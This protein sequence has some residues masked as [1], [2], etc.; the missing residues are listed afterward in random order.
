[1]AG[2][3]KCAVGVPSVGPFGDP[4]LLVELGRGC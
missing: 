3:L 1:M 4:V 2:E